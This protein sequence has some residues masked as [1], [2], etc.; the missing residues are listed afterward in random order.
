MHEYGD[1]TLKKLSAGA[2]HSSYV[3]KPE[4]TASG[5]AVLVTYVSHLKDAVMECYVMHIVLYLM[6]T[7]TDSP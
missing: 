3:M 4:V 2:G 1:G 7:C 6:L 5:R